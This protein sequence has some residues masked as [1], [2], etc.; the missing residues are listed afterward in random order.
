MWRDWIS[1]YALHPEIRRLAY[2]ALYWASLQGSPSPLAWTR[3]VQVQSR[4]IPGFSAYFF[5]SAF[6]QAATLQAL[7]STL[8]ALQQFGAAAAH[9]TEA[10]QLEPQNAAAHIL[11]ARARIMRREFSVSGGG[12][13]T[14]HHAEN[15]FLPTLTCSSGVIRLHSVHHRT[16][17]IPHRSTE[18]VRYNAAFP[19]S[20]R[21]APC[22][23]S[24]VIRAWAFQLAYRWPLLWCI[25]LTIQS[26]GFML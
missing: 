9:C 5:A 4:L 15:S 11:R 24:S 2:C 13:S 20:A 18:Q 17:L 8:L 1:G 7:A 22:K 19:E 12:S 6:A 10:L 23:V 26:W 14:L 21:F 3:H 16:A 25:L